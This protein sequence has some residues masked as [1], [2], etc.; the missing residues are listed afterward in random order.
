M[1]APKNAL[2]MLIGTTV[3][4]AGVFLITRMTMPDIDPEIMPQITGKPSTSQG[5]KPGQVQTPA[6][7]AIALETD[8]GKSLTNASDKAKASKLVGMVKAAAAQ[9]DDA[10]AEFG[11]QVLSDMRDWAPVEC[12]FVAELAEGHPVVEFDQVG[13]AARLASSCWAVGRGSQERTTRDGF[14]HAVAAN[15]VPSASPEVARR[16]A[17][18]HVEGDLVYGMKKA[19]KLAVEWRVNGVYDAAP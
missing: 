13:G 11:I 2:A 4:A 3:F 5:F 16:I 9:G 6:M 8:L 19:G 15:A 7:R 10:R 18:D 14:Q 1:A 12:V 17:T